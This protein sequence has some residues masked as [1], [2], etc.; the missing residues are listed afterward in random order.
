MLINEYKL[1]NMAD[2]VF[3]GGHYLY[4]FKKDR[5]HNMHPFPSSIDR[6]HFESGEGSEDPDDQARIPSPR[7]GFF[8]VI[9]ERF[10]VVLLDELAEKMPDFQFIIIGPVVKIDPAILPR[11]RN[12]HYLGQKSYRELPQYLA[13]WDV[14]IL[15]FARNAST[16]FISPT[17][18]P[19]YLCAGKPVVSTSIHDV[20]HPYGVNG[21]VEIADNADD[22][23]K[24]IIKVLDYKNNAGWLAKVQDQLNGSS[25]DLTFTKMKDL[26]YKELM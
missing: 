8:G 6:V 3:T 18:T 11:H 17:K 14:A 16:R 19:E 26:I 12:I 4:E 1:F 23:S 10:D 20:V 2:V 25:W 13:H 22:F 15:P 5:H 7:V 21:I 24:A 9:D